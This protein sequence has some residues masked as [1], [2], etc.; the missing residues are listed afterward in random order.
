MRAVGG[1]ELAAGGRGHLRASHADRER[2]I[3]TLKAAF[4]QGMLDKDDFDLRVGRT[5]ASRTYAELAAVI[6]DLPAGLAAASTPAPAQAHGEQPVVRPVP[7][8]AAATAAYGGLWGY[9]LWLSPHG[10]DNPAAPALIFV[11]ALVYLG[12]VLICVTAVAA[13]RRER[14]SGGQP[15]RRP[16]PGP[17]GRA[18]RRFP[19]A[20]EGEGLPPG[21]QGPRQSSQAARRRV[22]R[23]VLPVHGPCSESALSTGTAAAFC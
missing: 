2:V 3:Y 21:H 4:V 8:L 19:S 6:A 22:S 23:P 17:G 12:I 14:H 16:P 15:R 20:G 5:F 1:A 7:V 10:G 11:S 9:V 13:V 18:F